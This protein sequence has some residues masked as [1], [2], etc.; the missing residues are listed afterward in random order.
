MRRI[1][2]MAYDEKNDVILWEGKVGN[3]CMAVKQYNG[4]TPKLQIGPR[5]VESKG[6]EKFMKAGRLT[7]EELDYIVESAPAIAQAIEG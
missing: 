7:V 1:A 3:L 4:G 6:E 2:E 5:I